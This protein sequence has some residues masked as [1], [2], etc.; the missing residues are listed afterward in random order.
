MSGSLPNATYRQ[1]AELAGFYTVEE[2]QLFIEGSNLLVP[3]KKAVVRGDDGRYLATV[4]SGYLHVCRKKK[5]GFKERRSTPPRA[6]APGARRLS[7]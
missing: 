2:K 1:I 5:C 4:G 6:N 7:S 3:D